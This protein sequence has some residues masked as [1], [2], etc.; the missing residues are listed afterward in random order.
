VTVDVHAAR[1]G[2]KHPRYRVRSLAE[3]LQNEHIN[4]NNPRERGSS[5]SEESESVKRNMKEASW[6]ACGM[7]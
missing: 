6:N 3:V 1:R 4:Y 5:S 2:I 7:S